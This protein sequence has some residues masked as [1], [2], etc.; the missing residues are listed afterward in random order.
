MCTHGFESFYDIRLLKSIID[1][2]PNASSQT[3]N[4]NKA[5]SFP[6]IQCSRLNLHLKT[7]WS[8]GLASIDLQHLEISL[9]QSWA[10]RNDDE[11][12]FRQNRLCYL[13]KK[14]LYQKSFPVGLVDA[15]FL[16]KKGP[17]FISLIG[18]SI[19]CRPTYKRVCHNSDTSDNIPIKCT[20]S[21][22]LMRASFTCP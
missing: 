19:A 21:R 22:C 16:A 12:C 9:L 4:S 10:L 1:R 7:A 2:N 20:S 11:A 3:N 6:I 5:S 14:N 18:K 15:P 13:L 8:L 17:S